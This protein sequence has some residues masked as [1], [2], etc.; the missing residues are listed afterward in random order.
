MPM[1]NSS[2][3]NF[4]GFRDFG[5]AGVGGGVGWMSVVRNGSGIF[6]DCET[7]IMCVEFLSSGKS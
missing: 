6:L 7:D 4:S 1:V 3:F 2:L 5:S